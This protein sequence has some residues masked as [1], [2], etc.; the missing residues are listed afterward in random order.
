[1]KIRNCLMAFLLGFL[2]IA[3][4]AAGS[5][6]NESFTELIALTNDAIES[7][8]QGDSAAFIQKTQATLEALKVQDEKGSSIRLQRASAKLKAALKA[9]NAGNLPDGV[10]DLQQGIAIMNIA[11]K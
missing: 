1:M 11:K 5:P 3:V 10:A 7:G 4:Q 6:L 8:N 2:P 9:A